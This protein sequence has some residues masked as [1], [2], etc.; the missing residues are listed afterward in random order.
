MANILREVI[1]LPISTQPIFKGD[2]IVV[3]FAGDKSQNAVFHGAK[4]NGKLVVRKWRGK[5]KQFT[6]PV[7]IAGTDVLEKLNHCPIRELREGY[8]NGE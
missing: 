5:S 7:E 3:R 1:T 8:A 2:W 4:D 6:G